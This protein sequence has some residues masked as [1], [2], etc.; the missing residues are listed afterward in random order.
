[1]FTLSETLYLHAPKLTVAHCILTLKSTLK[2][3]V[4]CLMIGQVPFDQRHPV[5]EV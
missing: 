5:G 1:M 4:V 2:D 3:L